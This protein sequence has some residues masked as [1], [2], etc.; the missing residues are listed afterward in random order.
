[1]GACV[2]VDTNEKKSIVV[3]GKICRSRR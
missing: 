3:A 1:M 2:S